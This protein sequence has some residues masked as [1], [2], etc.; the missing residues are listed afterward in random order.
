MAEYAKRLQDPA[1]VTEGDARGHYP[2]R[3][4]AQ[5]WVSDVATAERVRGRL[6]SVPAGSGSWPTRSTGKARPE[7][8][9]ALAGR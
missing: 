8:S 1:R 2:D 5:Q 7:S 6:K 4:A 9:R 3:P